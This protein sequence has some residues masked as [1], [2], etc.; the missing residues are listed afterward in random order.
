MYIKINKAV[1][2]ADGEKRVFAT[3]RSGFFQQDEWIFIKPAREQQWHTRRVKISH[4]S[5]N[6][7]RLGQKQ[8]ERFFKLL[9]KIRFEYQNDDGWY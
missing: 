3:V 1:I 7:Q 5:E 9:P 4:P 2:R 6:R 8:M